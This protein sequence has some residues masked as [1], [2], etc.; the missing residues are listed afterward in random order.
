[1]IHRYN[2]HRGYLLTI[3]MACLALKYLFKEKWSHCLANLLQDFSWTAKPPTKGRM[4]KIYAK[5]KMSPKKNLLFFQ[6][7]TK[8]TLTK[9]RDP[10]LKDLL[11]FLL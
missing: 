1:M 5:C 2:I 10:K 4:I 11:D 7:P 6:A 3:K 8:M 9:S